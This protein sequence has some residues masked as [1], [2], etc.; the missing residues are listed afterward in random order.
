MKLT[1]QEREQI[2]GKLNDFPEVNWD[3]AA[4]ADS[5]YGC[6]F[7]WIDREDERK[8]FMVLHWW[9]QDDGLDFSFTTS[10]AALSEEM[11]R[12]LGHGDEH[13]DCERVEDLFPDVARKILL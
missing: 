3:R 13:A 11:A 5:S 10:S 2:T 7:G 4:G 8:D 6:A 12:R 9:K 1:D